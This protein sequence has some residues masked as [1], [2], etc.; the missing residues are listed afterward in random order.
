MK[1]AVVEPVHAANRWTRK[2]VQR[3]GRAELE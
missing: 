2:E 3:K 1:L